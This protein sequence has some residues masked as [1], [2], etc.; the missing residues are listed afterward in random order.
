MSKNLSFESMLK[1]DIS[2]EFIAFLKDYNQFQEKI[3][4]NSNN[5]G[6][7]L[8]SFFLLIISEFCIYSFV[9][10]ELN[11]KIMTML[12]I[13]FMGLATCGKDI[14]SVL[15]NAL[16]KKQIKKDEKLINQKLVD[17]LDFMKKKENR[18]NVARNLITRIENIE[19]IKL[20]NIQYEQIRNQIKMIKENIY[21]IFNKEINEMD[22]DTI[23]EEIQKIK[24]IENKVA[25]LKS[26]EQQLMAIKNEMNTGLKSNVSNSF[27]ENK[28]TKS[29]S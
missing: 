19:S 7:L 21:K 6:A 24:D 4:K 15:G 16:N 1:E 29:F 22:F 10:L 2:E 14:L 17:W 12:S 23:E 13:L 18:F 11:L 26:E 20:E 8:V 28:D 9:E 25:Y 5:K 27:K 3:D